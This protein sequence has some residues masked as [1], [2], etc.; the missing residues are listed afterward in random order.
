MHYGTPSRIV[1]Y[2]TP[3]E[4]SDEPD[5]YY[6]YPNQNMT[7]IIDKIRSRWPNLQLVGR[8]GCVEY[9]DMHVAIDKAIKIADEFTSTLI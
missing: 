3:Y 6:P 8:L 7:S 4:A 9:I 2:E 5:P 1:S